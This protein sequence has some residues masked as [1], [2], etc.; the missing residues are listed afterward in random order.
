MCCGA[1]KFARRICKSF[2]RKLGVVNDMSHPFFFT[3]SCDHG[4][5]RGFGMR[6]IC[7]FGNLGYIGPVLVQALR[8]D[9]ETEIFGYDIGYFERCYLS[10]VAEG[11][12]VDRQYYGDVRH[13][14]REFLEGI[15]SVVY[16]AAISNDPMG[17]KYAQPT[18]AI[19]DRAAVDIAEQAKAAGVSSFVFAS[20]CS[21]YGAGGDAPK[22]EAD[23]TDPLTDYAVSKISAE[24][25]LRPLADENFAITCLRFA[26]ACGPSPRMRLD[27]VLNDFVASAI[28]D[29]RITILSDGTPLRPLIDTR[30][31]AR[32]LIWAAG[33]SSST[34]GPFLVV[35]GGSNDWNFSVL[36]IAEYV[37]DHF[38]AVDIDVN[39]NAGPDNR[40][41]RVDFSLFR[42][43]APDAYP[44][45]QLGE[46]I[47]ALAQSL[48]SASK[49]ISDFRGSHFIRLNVLNEMRGANVLD[50]DLR[51]LT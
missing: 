6:R 1:P 51:W 32:A 36:E 35:N 18:H 15:D 41:Y 16:L 19:N 42:E 44:T 14:P 43:L 25:S 37:R 34:G 38:G 28:T 23:P 49:L 24:R 7:I 30:D 22:T 50:D 21:V 46:T 29:K 8:E 5:E 4:H 3:E 27:L 26:T 31:M 48:T 45:R 2:L 17:R 13:L 39:R 10:P 11:R 40:S 20:S 33:R 9:P 47:D 12:G